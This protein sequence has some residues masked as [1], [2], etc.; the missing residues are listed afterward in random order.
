M[1]Q[2]YSYRANV[3]EINRGTDPS[4]QLYHTPRLYIDGHLNALSQIYPHWNWNPKLN[5]KL[6]LEFQVE[7]GFKLEFQVE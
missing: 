7:Y 2:T 5:T 1:G 3:R 6:R 4:L